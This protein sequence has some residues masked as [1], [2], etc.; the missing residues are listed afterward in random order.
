MTVAAC[1]ARS[2]ANS[3]SGTCTSAISGSRSVTWKVRSLTLMV[4]P[5]LMWRAETT[6]AMGARISV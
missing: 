2:F 3:R 5:T 6:P 1:S 4:L